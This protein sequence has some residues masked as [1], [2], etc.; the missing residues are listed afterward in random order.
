MFKLNNSNQIS[1]YDSTL[2]LSEYH[3]KILN[4]S[5]AGYFRENIFPKINE[6]SFS[7]LYSEKGSRPNTPVNIMVG[8]LILK[9]LN[10]LT[11][12]ELMEALIFDT[13]YQYALCTTDYEKQPI[14]RNAF[15]N[16]RNSLIG[17]EIETG[18]DL[19]KEEI[20]R[21]SNEINDCCKKDSKLK[22]MDSMMISAR[23]KPLSRLDLVY[24]VNVNFISKVKE[25]LSTVLGEREKAYLDKNFKKEN[26]YEVTKENHQEKLASL[27]NDSKML[28][29]KYKSTKMKETEEFKLLE[30]LIGEQIDN[31][32]G[33]PKAS[34]EISPRSMQNPSEPDATYRFKYGD[35]IGYVANVVE[36]IHE[37]NEIYI[38]DYDYKPNVTSDKEFM[39]NYIESKDTQEE[40]TTLVD[41]AYYSDQINEKAKEKNINLVP[42]QTMGK[43]GAKTYISNFEI[44][45]E[46]HKVLSC[47]NGENPIETNY[48]SDKHLYTAKF[49]K[50]KCEN[51]P[52][53][54]Q[55]EK[56]KIIKKKTTSIKF[57]QEAYHKAKLEIK[58]TQ[59]EYKKLSNHRAG[60]EGT[61][62]VLRRKYHV[63][64]GPYMG[65]LRSKLKFGGSILSINIKKAIKYAKNKKNL[66]P[67]LA[68]LE[69]LHLC[70]KTSGLKADIAK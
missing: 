70:I 2:Y 68:F 15:T 35:N 50:C 60:I 21:I 36:D 69:N 53:R 46:N 10:Q 65:L 9:E 64:K 13:R 31:T 38:T 59:E 34:K 16:F 6:Q 1:I 54:Q 27:L 51:C 41:A 25:E 66:A 8:L 19:Y 23:C 24:R 30:R 26:V 56:E 52:F 3:Q 7:V 17:Y 20:L 44:D 47:P 55:C 37:N 29:D 18:V 61:M 4:K 28:Y 57:T 5:W 45:E 22:R 40:E 42:T 33:T 11:D 63:D 14:S 48:K 32:T 62:S 43:T 58:M 67:I 12:A 39:E 49:D